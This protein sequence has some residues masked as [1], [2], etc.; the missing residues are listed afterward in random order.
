M[1]F[2]ARV[3]EELAGCGLPRETGRLAPTGTRLNP[4][5]MASPGLAFPYT[6]STIR[7]NRM[8]HKDIWIQPVAMNTTRGGPGHLTRL[9]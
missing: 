8:H 3:E 4:T 9:D 1:A 2:V 7:L 6:P 5:E